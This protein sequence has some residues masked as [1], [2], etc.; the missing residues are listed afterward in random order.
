MPGTDINA[1]RARALLVPV[2]DPQ[3]EPDRPSSVAPVLPGRPAPM[4]PEVRTL[5][6]Q[7]L[8]GGIAC[9]WCGTP[10]RPD[11]HFCSRCAMSMAASSEEGVRLPWWRRVFDYR[12]REL[13]WGGAR[14]RLRWQIGRILRWIVWAAVLGLVVTGLFHVDD[15]Y[16]AV[17]D[18][19]ATR[20]SVAPDSSKASRSYPSHGAGLAFDK[21]S[22]TWWGPGVAGTGQGEWLEADFQEPV[23]LLNIGFTCGESTH[24]DTLSKSALPHRIQARI[25]MDDGKV[26]TQDLI[27]DQVSGFQQRNFQ[28]RNVR[29][30]RFNLETAYGIGAKKQVAIAE[31]EFFGPSQGG[32]S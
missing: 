8:Q 10:N 30:V 27:L 17:R 23:N 2:A 15:A 16:N 11:R 22:N 29:S 18:H 20:V 1:E 6:E 14:P 7:D 12:N 26:V 3:G 9:P 4:R 25:T 32:D 31:I 5:G 13:P 24:A 21:V 28:F 19:F